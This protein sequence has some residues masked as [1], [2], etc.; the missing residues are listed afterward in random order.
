VVVRV[1]AS[2]FVLF[3][4][5][6][7][8]AAGEAP[9]PDAPF[10]PSWVLVR[11]KEPIAETGSDGTFSLHTGF[12]AVDAAIQQAGV[13][14]IDHALP[15]A[16][17]DPQ[18]QEAH[19]QYGL[20]RTYKFWL[21]EGSDVAAMTKSFASLADVEYVEPDYEGSGG[22]VFPNDPNFS[23]QWGLNQSSDADVDAPEAWGAEVGSKVII[24]V[25]DTGIDASHADLAGKILPGF[26]FANNDG[27]PADDHGHGT[28][29]SSIASANSNN[30]VGIAGSCWNCK[31]M[32]L[33]VLDSSSNGFYS[34]WADAMVW[35]ADHGARVISL[36][37]GGFS[38]S[39]TLLTGVEYAHD[40][41]VIHISI[42]HN[43]NAN[44]VRY[45]GAYKE[46][47]A[48]GATDQLDRRVAPFCYSSTS[49][50]N[51][52]N[53]IDVVAPGELILGAALGG[54]YNYWCGT[55]QAAPLV[56]GLVGI[57]ETV[58]P[59]VGREE[60][61]H[62]LRAG[63]DDQ[64]GRPAEDIPGFDI[65]HGWGRVN[66]DRTLQ[67]TRAS[68][69][70]RVEGK[71][72]TRAFFQ[73]ANPLAG[74]YDFIRG[75]LSA[76]SESVA[77]VNLGT[78][79]CLENDSPD[80]DTAGN[81]DAGIPTP[82]AAF[83]YL[84]RFNAAPGPGGYGGSS[85]NR[86]REPLSGGCAPVCGNGVREGAEV[87]DGT[88]LGGETCVSQGYEQGTLACGPLCDGFDTS[89]CAVCFDTVCETLGGEDCL[90]C[91]FDCNGIQSGDP[92]SRYC[93]GDGDGENP[94]PCSDPRCT[95]NGNLCLP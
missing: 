77:G 76:L 7:P 25:L 23:L 19:Q 6:A 1:L 58:Y 82:G 42:T 33:K 46:T 14:R 65:Y 81:E 10:S 12:A 21:P 15:V 53:E 36:S 16:M 4:T 78:V 47:I 31:I 40:A 59:S 17:S 70:L 30:G 44:L 72:S 61:R 94:V 37:A 74:S 69:T 86:D 63:A 62:L 29:V 32:P 89:A 66:M 57:M 56:S 45:P 34:W 39:S 3:L 85:R 49:G 8:V 50:S 95:A 92:G 64:V 2:L 5:Q 60:A 9:Q 35:A 80:P 26:D 27:N 22:A 90:S 55:S 11:L 52:G 28:N 73:T 84:A 41:G 38:D 87:C 88:D 20:D 83:F 75:N 54:G 79:A 93:C 24:A 43:D 91:P 51:F 13:Y 68:T 48:V 18:F 67:A 71:S